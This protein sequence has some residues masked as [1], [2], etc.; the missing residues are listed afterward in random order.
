VPRSSVR[1]VP[2]PTTLRSKPLTSTEVTRSTFVTSYSVGG[3]ESIDSK[4][5]LV[6]NSDEYGK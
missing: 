3:H 1:D 4:I 6:F 2:A 5:N